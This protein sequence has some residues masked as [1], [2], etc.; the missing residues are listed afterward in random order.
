M[1]LFSLLELLVVMSIIGIMAA[2]LLPA[3]GIARE[4]AQSIKCVSLMKQYAS[5]SSMY[6]D[7]SDYEYR[8]HILT[9]RIGLDYTICRFFAVFGRAE[10]QTCFNRGGYTDYQ[11]W[12]YDRWRLTVGF[13]FQY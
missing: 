7:D 10:Y 13:R 5:P 12:D 1:R 9:G 8:R 6:A 4:C 11:D 3:L 2:M